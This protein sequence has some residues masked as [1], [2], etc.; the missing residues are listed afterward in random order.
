[1]IGRE[2]LNLEPIKLAIEGGAVTI[3]P[4]GC[5]DQKPKRYTEPKEKEI[6]ITPIFESKNRKTWNADA[7]WIDIE[8]KVIS[9]LPDEEIETILHRD[10]GTVLKRFLKLI[11]QKVPETPFSLPVGLPYYA[12]ISPPSGKNLSISGSSDMT[13]SVIPKEAFFN[14]K[15]WI[16]LQS[17][18]ISGAEPEVWEDFVVDVKVALEE[19][20][21]KR[22]TI[23]AAIACEVFI[24]QYTEKASREAGI[25]RRFWKYLEGRRPRVLDYYDSILHL[26]KGHSLRTEARESYNLL[27]RL[28]D[29]RKKIVHEGKLP[30]SWS[31]DR[32]DQLREDIEQVETVISW[33]HAL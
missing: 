30:V 9:T 26:V 25:S 11:R 1:M 13:Y 7:L 23:Y 32:I 6:T 8:K 18:M 27:N 19:K 20:D 16:E 33:V 5:K 14:K 21:L 28:Y 31:S 2:V 4:P 12:A 22:A 3:Y 15:K 17:E 29:A 24:K 10:I